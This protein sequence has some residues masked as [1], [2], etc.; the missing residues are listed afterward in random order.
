M[1]VAIIQARMGSTRLPGKVLKEVDNKPLLAYQIERVSKSKLI[2]KIVIATSILEKD[3]VIEKFCKTNRI[4]C[5]RGSENDVLS[6]YYECAKIYN[7]DTIVRLTG[8]C[9][10]SD[11]EIIDAVIQKFLDDEVSYYAN[12]VPVESAT[13]PDGTDV[14]VFSMEALTKAFNEVK[15]THFREHVTFQFWQTG[16]YTSSQYIGI[17]N[18]SNY[19]LTVDYPEDFNVIKYILDI[20]SLKNIDGSLEEIIEILDLNSDIKAKNNRYSFGEGWK[21]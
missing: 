12:T 16:E 3:D 8:D 6:R 7:A 15:D 17:K 18:L 11:P 14:E 4:E 2:D 19:R 20:I 5:F 21:K 1:T 9:P 13:F 10:L